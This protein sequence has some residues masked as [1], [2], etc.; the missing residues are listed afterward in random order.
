M[1]AGGGQRRGQ[2]EVLLTWRRKLLPRSGPRCTALVLVIL[3]FFFLLLLLRRPCCCCCAGLSPPLPLVG[4]GRP[5]GRQ[6]AEG[7]TP[8][9]GQ[10]IGSGQTNGVHA[11]QVR[12]YKKVVEQT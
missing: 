4:H 11:G 1:K 2:E 12:P 10:S 9:S 7:R 8:E 3:L 6:G 5:G